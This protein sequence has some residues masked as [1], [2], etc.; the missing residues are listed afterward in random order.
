MKYLELHNKPRAV[1][2]LDDLPMDLL[3]EEE[4]D[5][6]G[7]G[8]AGAGGGGDKLGNLS[9]TN[10]YTRT[11]ESDDAGKNW[12]YEITERLHNSIPNNEIKMKIG[13]LHAKLG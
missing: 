5:K 9:I 8:G 11:E 12:F 10:V 4:E 2:H 13:N 6:G 3:E 7:G 1:V